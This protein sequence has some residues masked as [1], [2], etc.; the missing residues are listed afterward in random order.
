VPKAKV[1]GK[2]FTCEDHEGEELKNQCLQDGDF[3]CIEC[4][5]DHFDHDLKKNRVKHTEASIK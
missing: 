2:L 5:E 3:I 4:L 1:E